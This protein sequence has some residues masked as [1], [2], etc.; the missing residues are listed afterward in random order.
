MLQPLREPQK[1]ESTLNTPKSLTGTELENV[2]KSASKVVD[3]AKVKK[4]TEETPVMTSNTQPINEARKALALLHKEK[5]KIP[6]I[7]QGPINA[8]IGE[9]T[10]KLQAT[11]DNYF[12]N[13]LDNYLDK[14]DINMT[15]LEDLSTEGKLTEG[16]MAKI[17]YETTRPVVGGLGGF[18]LS[19]IVGDEDD[20]GLTVGM[21]LAGAG[22]GTWQSLLRRSKLTSIEKETGL[23]MVNKYAS[24]NAA[25]SAKRLFAGTLLPSWM[26]WEDTPRWLVTCCSRDKEQALTLLKPEQ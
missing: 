16:I 4:A 23:L 18:A 8:R 14:Q 22:L 3:P 10:T 21:T 6:K 5:K 12:N 24:N 25:T 17:L 2:K 15:M 1:L 7:D 26:Q 11:R 9:M 19:G 20:Y 13:Q